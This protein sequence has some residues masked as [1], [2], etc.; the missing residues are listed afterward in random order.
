MPE[1]DRNKN[2]A[3]AVPGVRS[4]VRSMMALS[5]RVVWGAI[6]TIL[7]SLF[8]T[9]QWQAP[10]WGRWAARHGGRIAIHTGSNIRKYP[11]TAMAVVVLIVTLLCAGRVLYQWWQAPL[12][13]IA[14]SLRDHELRG[15]RI[16]TADKSATSPVIPYP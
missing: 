14:V 13:P 11:Q 16:V 6:R 5:G 7:T 12:Q 4:K 1:P 8:G 15:A 3:A 9:V 10:A 2:V